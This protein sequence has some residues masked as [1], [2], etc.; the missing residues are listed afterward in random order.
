MGRYHAVLVVRSSAG[1]SAGGHGDLPTVSGRH[2]LRCNTAGADGVR[3]AR[4]RARASPLLLREERRKALRSALARPQPA[5]DQWGRRTVAAW[6]SARLG[7]LSGAKPP[8]A[9]AAHAHF[10]NPTPTPHPGEPG[11]AGTLYGASAPAPAR[12]RDG[13]SAGNRRAVGRISASR[14]SVR[15][16]ARNVCGT[17]FADT[18]LASEVVD[19]RAKCAM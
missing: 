2:V 7:R 8:G 1:S 4:R 12:G 15:R 13:V 5:D 19:D 14:R 3:D 18:A 16:S 11:G 17:L 9:A 10:L 6:M